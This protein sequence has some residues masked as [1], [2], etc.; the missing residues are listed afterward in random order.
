MIEGQKCQ[1]LLSEEGN[2][3]FCQN[4]NMQDGYVSQKFNNRTRSKLSHRDS[5]KSK[6][7]NYKKSTENNT[8]REETSKNVEG[9]DGR[10]MYDMKCSGRRGKG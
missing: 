1:L 2:S 6:N 7:L 5:K 9:Q 3:G 4:S 10:K 8:N